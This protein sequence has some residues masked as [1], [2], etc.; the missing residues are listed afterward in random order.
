MHMLKV[1]VKINTPLKMCYKLLISDNTFQKFK[2]D[3]Q[4][5]STNYF[6]RAVSVKGYLQLF[7]FVLLS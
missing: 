1:S 3:R 4:R 7:F 5:I 6:N 2:A